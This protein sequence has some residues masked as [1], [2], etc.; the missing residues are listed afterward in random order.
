[1]KISIENDN[2]VLNID[3]KPV[4]TEDSL[5]KGLYV[6]IR[7]LNGTYEGNI[8]LTKTTLEGKAMTHVTYY[9]HPESQECLECAN[10]KPIPNDNSGC[11]CW[12]NVEK[13]EWSE[14]P[15]PQFEEKE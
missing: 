7:T 6:V 14:D 12:K 10:G 13:D 2:R 3:L 11:I 8:P 15:C 9:K 5:E 1:M 4:A